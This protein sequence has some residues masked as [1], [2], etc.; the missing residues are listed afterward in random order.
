MFEKVKHSYRPCDRILF[1]NRVIH[2]T[3]WD[4]AAQNCCF[5]RK[6]EFIFGCTHTG[7]F[8]TGESSI[9]RTMVTPTDSN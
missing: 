8:V 4:R 2:I 9:L 3:G 7:T 6:F 1:H 5:I